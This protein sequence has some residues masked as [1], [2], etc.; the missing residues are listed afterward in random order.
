M[1][2]Y[3]CDV[4]NNFVDD[5]PDGVLYDNRD[6]KTRGFRYDLCPACVEKA[7]DALFG[8]KEVQGEA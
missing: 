6:K 8:K 5:V 1:K 3:K 4:C 7:L 2:A